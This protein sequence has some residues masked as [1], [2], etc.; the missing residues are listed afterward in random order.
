M[1]K[2]ALVLAVA[3]LLAFSAPAHSQS[4]S[5]RD[6]AAVERGRALYQRVG[7]YQ[8]HNYSGNGGLAGP[9]LAPN[10]PPAPLFARAVR[11]PVGAMPAYPASIL[12]DAGVAD[13]RAYLAS[14]P[15]PP[16]VDTI[17]LLRN[18]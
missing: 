4:A 12:D 18:E 17:P 7:C 14:L 15:P 8:C 5:G 10:P 9:R 3:A 13:I 16:P 11:N 2:A 1:A 6:A